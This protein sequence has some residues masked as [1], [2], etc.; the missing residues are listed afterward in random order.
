MS[1]DSNTPPNPPS[2]Q[3]LVPAGQYRGQD[4]SG[5]TAFSLS[6]SECD[7]TQSELTQANFSQS[8]LKDAQ[9]DAA[10]LRASQFVGAI[11]HRVSARLADFENANCSNADFLQA[12]LTSAVFFNANLQNASL[13]NAHL[14][15]ADLRDANLFNADLS[16]TVLDG[17]D[18]AGANIEGA[19]LNHIKA[20][21]AR[22][23]GLQCTP[24]QRTILLAAGAYEG[25]PPLF[26]RIQSNSESLIRRISTLFKADTTESD[27]TGTEED[28]VDTKIDLLSQWQQQFKEWQER[29]KN[30]K[31]RREE[32]EES[33][34]AKQEA[35]RLKHLQRRLDKEN[36]RR[37]EKEKEDRLNR[38]KKAIKKQTKARK[39][40]MARLNRELRR[41]RNQSRSSPI[42]NRLQ[43]NQFDPTTDAKAIALKKASDDAYQ[44]AES[45]YEHETD[46]Q[47]SIL[48]HPDAPRHQEM[49]EAAETQTRQKAQMAI[50]A[51]TAYFDY[52]EAQKAMFAE[53]AIEASEQEKERQRQAERIAQEQAVAAAV[54]REEAEQ[55]AR[56]KIQ[57]FIFQ[58]EK[59]QSALNNAEHI[60]KRSREQIR[61]AKAA[62]RAERLRQE[63][64]LKR[65]QAE[66]SRFDAQVRDNI[67]DTDS[68]VPNSLLKDLDS[69]LNEQASQLKTLSDANA[70]VSKEGILSPSIS[71]LFEKANEN[72]EKPEARRNKSDAE[73]QDF[74]D[75]SDTEP[76][77]PTLFA[78]SI[79]ASAASLSSSE[80]QRLSSQI[81]ESNQSESNKRSQDRLKALLNEYAQTSE[82]DMDKHSSS[83]PE[84]HQISQEELPP[85]PNQSLP[86]INESQNEIEV[87]FNLPEGINE[88]ESRTQSNEDTPPIE[89]DDTNSDSATLL[90]WADYNT[91]FLLNSKEWAL[92]SAADSHLKT[93]IDQ[94]SQSNHLED[95]KEILSQNDRSAPELDL[96]RLFQI[97]KETDS[98]FQPQDAPEET[99]NDNIGLQ[100]QSNFDT[101]ASD[102]ATNSESLDIIN[103]NTLLPETPLDIF[104][105]IEQSFEEEQI[106]APDF[107]NLAYLLLESNQLQQRLIDELNET[108][109]QFEQKKIEAEREKAQEADARKAVE[110]AQKALDTQRK[111]LNKEAESQ[112]EY[113]KRQRSLI[114][115]Q[116]KLEAL[117]EAEE[118]KKL[119][120]L[121]AAQKALDDANLAK[122]RQEKRVVEAQKN[123]YERLRSLQNAEINRNRALKDAEIAAQKHREAQLRLQSETELRRQKEDKARAKAA[124]EAQQQAKQRVS[125]TLNKLA[126]E[127]QKR[128]SAEAKALQAAEA[129][130]RALEAERAAKQA[131]EAE[132][133]ELETKEARLKQEEERRLAEA[134]LALQ[135]QE[136]E[137]QAALKRLSDTLFAEAEAQEDAEAQQK[138]RRE[139]EARTRALEAQQQLER[140]TA[141]AKQ[142]QETE[143]LAKQK[144]E[145]KAEAEARKSKA[146]S[147]AELRQKSLLQQQR[148]AQA[149][150]LVARQT[151]IE[152]AAKAAAERAELERKEVE[153]RLE[154][155]TKRLYDRQ[156]AR[157]QR[158]ENRTEAYYLEQSEANRSALLQRL[159]SNSIESSELNP[160]AT[161]P[162][163]ES[164]FQKKWYK[165][166]DFLARYS[167]NLANRLD[168]LK[169]DLETR[170]A[171]R[172]SAAYRERERQE[173]E[174]RIAKAERE[175][176][177]HNARINRLRGLQASAER[178]AEQ[179]LIAAQKEALQKA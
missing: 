53:A 22:I 171:Q 12:N 116:A 86:E 41:I 94:L 140:E 78:R 54:L 81:G 30:L 109:A 39:Q 71:D 119:D 75:P 74:I 16:H 7:F 51:E 159:E 165:S 64:E 112:S 72:L 37:A 68:P 175:R 163:M 102:M 82:I 14:Q 139:A 104:D 108:Q 106:E 25:L 107:T 156:T 48:D 154:L 1:Q 46:L 178:E 11:L 149:A 10:R 33:W 97:P 24:E 50:A 101:S 166:T 34:R 150:E 127:Q 130:K 152:M 129:V 4:L 65:Y 15:H 29:Q 160:V 13:R 61:A 73:N 118:Q 92:I 162:S 79:E 121:K 36:K 28:T 6:L 120:K 77:V 137:Q 125:L 56:L 136:A 132:R 173:Y 115:Q 47:G 161:L 88:L 103:P 52:L 40:Q 96:Y 174:N 126:L 2:N 17:A 38:Q 35:D 124:L 32:E 27:G 19:Q 44:A 93:Q 170:F 63:T 167:P 114:E 99:L 20:K 84:E 147:L 80:D 153:A 122:E 164:P 43:S 57:N 85:D 134:K 155:L 111:L 143:A 5:L 123:A 3:N 31:L 95:L 146:E 76:H 62:E 23:H 157:D 128:T 179:A 145:A 58:S 90:K 9:F 45:A 151:K 177:E 113:L 83:S 89:T 148:A 158:L 169:E 138:A 144:L 21:G 70:T 49:L 100:E 18:L 59:K 69:L 91:A 110:L 105:K 135:R 66:Q 67:P 8:D 26:A 55:R 117:S 168:T 172:K 60:A 176:V 87:P 142:K 133:I 42:F 131:L 98:P 141:I